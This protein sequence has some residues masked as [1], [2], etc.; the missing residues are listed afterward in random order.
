M[1]E[2]TDREEFFSLGLDMEVAPGYII[3]AVPLGTGSDDQSNETK[4]YAGFGQA[5]Y[6]LSDQLSV[7]FGS[8]YTYEE[9]RNS[10]VGVA[11]PFAVVGT[12]ETDTTESWNNLSSKLSLQY[13]ANDDL[14]L[15]C[16]LY[17]SPSP[18]D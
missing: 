3:G 1:S 12:F 4:S 9:K 15:Y 11:D 2:K 7:T 6:S 17:T 10:R 16:L 14:F 8:R 13:Q 18:R 5:T